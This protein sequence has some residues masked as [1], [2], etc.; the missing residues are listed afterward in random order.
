MEAFAEEEQWIQV[1]DPNGKSYW[2]NPKTQKT[3][4]TDP[5]KSEASASTSAKEG[6][7]AAS[8]AFA[9]VKVT[10]MGGL[11]SP[12]KDVNK[13][14][15]IFR[16]SGWNQFDSAPGE[17]D[18]K[19]E[20]L[21][22]KSELVMVGSSPVKSATDVNVLGPVDKVGASLASKKKAEL[23]E[24]KETERSGIRFYTFVF[25][26]GDDK[27]GAREV[28]Q[29]CVNKGKLWSVTATTAEKRWNKRK[30]LYSTIF[31]SFVPKL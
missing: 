13:G 24:A 11:L 5:N 9:D 4:A 1:D 12:F 29:L 17:Y 14:F 25:K 2:Y 10:K 19:W 15:Q 23:V 18:V 27:T 8:G 21:V 16:P 31:S 30:D 7:S 26:A 20:D 22:E 28:Y 6:S 3:S